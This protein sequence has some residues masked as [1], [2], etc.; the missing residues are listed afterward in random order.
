MLPEEQ[1]AIF[2]YIHSIT[3]NKRGEMKPQEYKINLSYTKGGEEVKA[4]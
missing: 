3:D 1:N 2:D 4:A